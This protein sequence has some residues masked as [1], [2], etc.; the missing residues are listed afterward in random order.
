ML[1]QVKE[2][3]SRM[4]EIQAELESKRFTADSG[5]GAVSVTVDGKGTLVDVKIAASAT[6]DVEL[7]EDLVKSAV[8]AAVRKSQEAMQ[9][10]MAKLTGGMN[11]PGITE[12]LGGQ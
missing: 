12:M 2:F 8:S 4:A 9:Q 3:Q 10:E 5:G 6:A 1:K 11:I 7:L